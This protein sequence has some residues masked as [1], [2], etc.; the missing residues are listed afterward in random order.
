MGLRTGTETVWEGFK[1]M[2]RGR[3]VGKG[4]REDRDTG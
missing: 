3:D 1:G 2:R 4:E